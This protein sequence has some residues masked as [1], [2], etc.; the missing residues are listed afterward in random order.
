MPCVVRRP[1]SIAGTTENRQQTTDNGQRTM[2]KLL[3]CWRYLQTRYLALACIVSVMLGVATLI[4]VNSVMAGFSKKLRERL[5]ALLSD[6][7]IEAKTFEGFSD[8]EGKMARILEDSYLRDRI[9]AM[10]PTLEV[11]AMVQFP[12]GGE[13]MTRPVRLIGIDPASRTRVGGFAEYVR[14]QLGRPAPASFEPSE[15]A[16]RRHAFQYP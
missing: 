5:H 16:R 1:S 2:Y 10:T 15:E 12:L 13:E 3:L 14:D 7:V 6:V 11:F 9:E 4:V 8:P